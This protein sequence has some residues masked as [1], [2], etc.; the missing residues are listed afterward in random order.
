[1]DQQLQ[2]QYLQ[3]LG[4]CQYLPRDAV[5]EDIAADSG[6]AK[7]AAHGS[8]KA[9]GQS[10]PVEIAEKGSKKPGDL[11]ALVNLDFDNKKPASPAKPKAT[12]AARVPPVAEEPQ[13]VT[14]IEVSFS[15]WQ[16]SEELLVCT[17]VEGA[18][19]DTGQM[20]LLTNILNAI[21]CGI[22]RLPQME[23]V[24]WPPYPNAPGD[25]SEVR[26]FLV[27]LLNGRL[28]SK[29]VK[30]ILFL[31]DSAANWLLSPGLQEQKETGRVV[32]SEQTTAL[33]LP[34]LSSMIENPQQK[35]VAWKT[36]QYMLPASSQP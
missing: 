32:I 23:L 20:Q 28:D 15:F 10:Q 7:S 4:I 30:S 25:E 31:G 29:P 22:S 26:E 9:D 33:L 16:A 8:A 5:Y 18:L 17:A 11:A 34:S 2:Y 35:A 24:E 3:T 19:A 1:M 12:K 13:P 14:A 6:T 36:L 21:G 27:T